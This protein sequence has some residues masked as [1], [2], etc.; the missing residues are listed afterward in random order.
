MTRPR[1]QP[2]PRPLASVADEREEA[3]ALLAAFAPWV[4][5]ALAEVVPAACPPGADVVLVVVHASHA[6]H[7]AARADHALGAVAAQVRA[8][9]DEVVLLVLARAD[10]DGLARALGPAPPHLAHHLPALLAAPPAAGEHVVLVLAR[11]L[12]VRLDLATAS[13][14]APARVVGEVRR[15]VPPRYAPPPAM[16]RAEAFAE[17]LRLVGAFAAELDA[18]TRVLLA[19]P[20]DAVGLLV[21]HASNALAS[22]EA[23]RLFASMDCPTV[24]DGEVVAYL[25]TVHDCA[26][27]VRVF[28]AALPPRAQTG[29][30][31]EL[32]RFADEFVA[33]GRRVATTRGALLYVAVGLLHVPVRATLGADGAVR[34]A[35]DIAAC[36]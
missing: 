18:P 21:A 17:A 24:A 1:Y 14:A 23:R 6:A 8:A 35:A 31:V 5:Q 9:D 33:M 7:A 25:L 36:S 10:A 3:C 29:P 34:Y 30:A 27:F 15:V 26:E 32:R 16:P 11:H 4:R 12:V 28:R 22:V 19:E 20:D 2:P 13:V